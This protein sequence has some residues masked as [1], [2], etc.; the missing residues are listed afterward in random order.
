MKL[1]KRKTN[2][3]IYRI[4]SSLLY[5]SNLETVI[6]ID[7]KNYYLCIATKPVHNAVFQR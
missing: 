4:F 5:K 3:I 2:L 1:K 7:W 6:Q